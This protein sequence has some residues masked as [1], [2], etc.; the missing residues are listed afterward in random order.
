M[1]DSHYEHIITLV[2]DLFL[3]FVHAI[4]YWCETLWLTILPDRYRQPKV[5]FADY[6]PTYQAR[7]PT[8]NASQRTICAT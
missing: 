3:F 5:S 6:A 1:Y 8:K 7:A 2:T 4:G